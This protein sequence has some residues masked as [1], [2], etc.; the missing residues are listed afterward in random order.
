ML[1]IPSCLFF[2]A[3]GVI[4]WLYLKIRKEMDPI[5]SVDKSPYRK[6]YNN[7]L[8]I[9]FIFLELYV[10]FKIITCLLFYGHVNGFYKDGDRLPIGA[11]WMLY[12][13]SFILLNVPYAISLYQLIFLNLRVKLY[14]GEIKPKQFKELFAIT[15]KVFALTVIILLLINLNLSL[16]E[17][18][19]HKD[20]Y[21]VL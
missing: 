14:G 6:V 15:K 3:G 4:L 18:Y 11:I 20:I 8:L 17:V 21:T 2:I 7:H 13:S 1:L 9:N 5:I 10:V 16:I 12:N 19:L